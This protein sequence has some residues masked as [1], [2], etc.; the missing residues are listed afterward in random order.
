MNP[1]GVRADLNFADSKYGE[2]AGDVTFEEAFTVQ[3]FN[4]YLV[5]MTLTGED[6]YNV[7][8]Q[9][10]TGSNAAAP[11]ILQ[12][13]KGFTY[14]RGP[15]GPVDG[16]VKL[17]GTPIDKAASYRIVTNNFLSD[18]GDNFPAFRNGTGKYFGGLDIDAFA[19]YLPTVSPYTPGA[20]TRITQ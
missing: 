13:S 15:A 17:N 11:N 20:L 3:P 7:L 19:N 18:G 16:S 14:Q 5:S 6:I 4:N 12:V 2:R 8:T 9:Q 10:V 1:G